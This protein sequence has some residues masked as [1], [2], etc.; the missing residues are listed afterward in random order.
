VSD[1]LL[2]PRA[3]IRSGRAHGQSSYTSGLALRLTRDSL[4]AGELIPWRGEDLRHASSCEDA[5]G[6]F[7]R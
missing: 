4:R 3:R 7:G 6:F 1:D 2:L 5:D